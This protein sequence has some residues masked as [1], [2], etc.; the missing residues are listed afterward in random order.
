M[1]LRISQVN[2]WVIYYCSDY[3]CTQA[4][5]TWQVRV[6]Y[7]IGSLAYGASN[8]N[9]YNSGGYLYQYQST[10]AVAWTDKANCNHT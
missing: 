5:E 6:Q 4:L 9:W 8:A 1:A 7:Q 3:Y 10:T 2:L